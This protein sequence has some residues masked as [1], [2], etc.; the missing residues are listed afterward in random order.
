MRDHNPKVGGS[1]PSPAT[2]VKYQILIPKNGRSKRPFLSLNGHNGN[3]GFSTAT[4]SSLRPCPGVPLYLLSG[5]WLV[6]IV[7]WPGRLQAR[8]PSRFCA[9]AE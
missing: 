7:D 1:N 3:R 6:G 8:A 9:H 4:R 2:P 5:Y